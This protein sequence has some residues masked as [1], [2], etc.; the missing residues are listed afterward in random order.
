M[1]QLSRPSPH[2][3][4][5]SGLLPNSGPIFPL[6]PPDHTRL[7]DICV[8]FPYSTPALTSACHPQPLPKLQPSTPSR[9][10]PFLPLLMMR[11]SLL[12]QPT[13][14]DG[15]ENSNGVQSSSLNGSEEGRVARVTRLE[16]MDVTSLP[17]REMYFERQL[18]L[19][20]SARR[21]EEGHFQRV[22]VGKT[23]RTDSSSFVLVASTCLFSLPSTQDQEPW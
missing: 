19:V 1:T 17:R 7:S 23:R 10:S 4:G 5:P 11:G 12:L 15:G 6:S 3:F 14:D 18:T 8:P 20:D 21:E 22:D 13:L 16:R 9:A 2:S